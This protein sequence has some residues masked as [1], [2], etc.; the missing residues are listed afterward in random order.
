[1]NIAI[2]SVSK[3][4]KILSSKL[5][6][7]LSKDPTIITV[8]TYHKNIKNNIDNIFIDNED[9][10]L[11]YD[12]I[13]GI[14]ATGILIRSIAK[15]IK[16]KAIDPA[17]LAMDDNGKFTISLLSGHLGR[18]NELALKISKLINSEPVITTA[19]DINNK[20]GIDSLSNKYYWEIINKNEILEFNKAIL[21][22]KNIKIFLNNDE[23]SNVRY[24]RDLNDFLT[25]KNKNTVE[26]ID[27]KDNEM[28]INNIDNI[29]ISSTITNSVYNSNTKSNQDEYNNMYKD[30]YFDI[31]ANFNNHYLFFKQKKLVVGIGSRADIKEKNVLNAIKLAMHNL[32]LPLGRIDAIATV[33][34]KSNEEGILKTAK[35]LKTPL[36]IVSLNEIRR[37]NNKTISHSDFV[38]NKFNIPGVAEPA[39]LIIANKNENNSKL[40][41]KKIAINGVTVAVAVSN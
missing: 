24:I 21:D 32:K 34:I 27:L 38:K 35:H 29:F 23:N 31:F 14:M 1:M 22:E 26:I 36:K 15:K 3:K 37:L 28:S 18:A 33:E 8:D 41:H 20:I 10:T 25:N 17:I 40:I 7:L 9:K 30:N 4:G 6:S 16:N 39:A 12:A 2:L 13:I 19:T 5:K 11:K